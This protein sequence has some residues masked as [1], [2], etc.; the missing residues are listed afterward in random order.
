MPTTE[1]LAFMD[2]MSGQARDYAEAYDPRFDWSRGEWER[3]LRDRLNVQSRQTR[4]NIGRGQQ[5]PER[6]EYLFNG[7]WL[8]QDQFNDPMWRQNVYDPWRQEQEDAWRREQE[9]VNR[10]REDRSRNRPGRGMVASAPQRGGGYG[11]GGPQEVNEIMSILDAVY[12]AEAAGKVPPG[13]YESRMAELESQ[14]EYS[15]PTGRDAS[16]GFSG[17]IDRQVTPA[18]WRGEYDMPGNF[19]RGQRMAN[20]MAEDAALRESMKYARRRGDDE[21]TGT[22]AL[23]RY[24]GAEQNIWRVE[25]GFG[26]QG[27]GARPELMS[28]DERMAYEEGTA[29]WA[30][31][32]RMLLG[33]EEPGA[34]LERARAGRGLSGRDRLNYFH[35]GR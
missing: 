32:Q 14:Y 22:Y 24:P 1:D 29:E 19:E 18:P 25:H 34:Q 9:E 33:M 28:Q 11:G 35:G 3:N 27:Y 5:G 20:S 26:G 31:H 2:M 10:L 17:R 15:M 23:S 4:D 21:P 30:K 13:T 6:W 12:K 7:E 8:N 16:D